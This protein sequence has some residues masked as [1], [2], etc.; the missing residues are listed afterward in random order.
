MKTRFFSDFA[1]L[2]IESTNDDRNEREKTNLWYFSFSHNESY[3]R[4]VQ[5]IDSFYTCTKCIDATLKIKE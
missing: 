3:K 4:D 5:S 2:S 1:I